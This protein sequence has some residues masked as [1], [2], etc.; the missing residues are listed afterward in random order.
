MHTKVDKVL[1]EENGEDVP[2]K[3]MLGEVGLLKVPYL[4]KAVLF[5]CKLLLTLGKCGCYKQCV[6]VPTALCLVGTCFVD[7]LMQKLSQMLGL[8]TGNFCSVFIDMTAMNTRPK[9]M[10][11]A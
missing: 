11:E 1:S 9:S 4:R 2:R 10:F 8:Q 3:G 5:C 6:F 7:N